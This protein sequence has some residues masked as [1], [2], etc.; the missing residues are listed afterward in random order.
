MDPSVLALVGALFGGAGLKIVD[1]YFGKKRARVDDAAR[2]R[3]E[4]RLEIN[5]Q[6][7]EIAKL[8]QQKDDWQ[9]K[10][11]DLRDEVSRL[12]TDLEFALRNVQKQPPPEN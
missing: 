4:L 3:D 1:H 2:I 6:K 7:E 10:Y 8:E 9:Q 12:K 5:S 11:Y